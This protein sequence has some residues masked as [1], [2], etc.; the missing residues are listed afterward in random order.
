M[1]KVRMVADPYPPYQ[2]EEEGKVRG[3]DHE[4][5]VAAFAVHGI[6]AQTRLRPW[7]E[8]L[9]YVERGKADGVF[10]VLPN[11]EREAR[12]LFSER[13]RTE[14]TLLLHAA[15]D[16]AGLPPGQNGDPFQGRRLGV[17][18][19]YSYGPAVDRLQGPQKVERQ[20]HEALLQALAAGEVD[21]VLMDAGVA[22]YLAGRLGVRGLEALP[23]YEIARPLHAAFRRQGAWMV[24]LFNAG[25]K[26]V[27]ENG[28]YDRILESYGLRT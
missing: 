19:G 6:T 23:G 4:I 24:R 17:L 11:P 18:E 26:T 8:C 14:K 12:F 1:R 20:S 13:L 27:R 16:P 25:L 7:R 28:I 3:V 9:E 15:R 5:V 2:Y 10:Q 21:L 22:A